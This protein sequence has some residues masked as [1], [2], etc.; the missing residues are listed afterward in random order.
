MVVR[1]RISEE[2]DCT[3]TDDAPRIG[4]MLAQLRKAFR[5]ELFVAK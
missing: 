2:R 4:E 3:G 5:G 1:G